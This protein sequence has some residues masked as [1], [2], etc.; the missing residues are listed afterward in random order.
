MSQTSDFEDSLLLAE[1][2]ESTLETCVNLS[3]ESAI[4]TFYLKLPKFYERKE[5][6]G[7]LLQIISHCELIRL[8]KDPAD[9]TLSVSDF[10]RHDHF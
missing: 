4:L 1:L 6:D 7:A 2:V 5:E 10:G 3:S 9:W 8:R